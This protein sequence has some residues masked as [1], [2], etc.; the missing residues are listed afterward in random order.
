MLATTVVGL[1][2][3]LTGCGGDDE[4]S[5]SAP[6]AQSTTAVATIA[7]ADYIT[8]ADAICKAESDATDQGAAAAIQELGTEEPTPEQLAT[9]AS[10]VVLPSL[11]KQLA[12]L[13]A[14]PKPDEGAADV[15]ALYAD[16]ETAIAAAKEDPS[17]LANSENGENPFA[18]ANKKAVAYGMKECG[19]E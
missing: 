12:A 8:Q 5:A 11:D 16:L 4:D 15:E 7:K 10:D 18:E 19:S 1:A 6:E 3:V 9:I 17:I 2:L 13:K 14:L